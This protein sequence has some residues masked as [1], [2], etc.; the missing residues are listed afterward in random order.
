M[1]DVVCTTFSVGWFGEVKQG[2]RTIKILCFVT[3]ETVNLYVRPLEG[4]TVVV[5]LDDL[6]I[7]EY[8]DRLVVPVPAAAGTDYRALK[9]RPPFGPQAVPVMVVQPEGTGFQIDGHMIR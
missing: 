3:G 7:V 1:K 4:I 5:D 9:Q 6:E 2:R 8:E